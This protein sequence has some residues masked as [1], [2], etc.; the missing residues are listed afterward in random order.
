MPLLDAIAEMGETGDSA[1]IVD[2]ASLPEPGGSVPAEASDP[3]D[4]DAAE[5]KLHDL[6]ERIGGTTYYF[7]KR[8]SGEHAADPRNRKHIALLKKLR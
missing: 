3:V 7:V 2:A 8:R 4:D 1:L 5:Q 6:D